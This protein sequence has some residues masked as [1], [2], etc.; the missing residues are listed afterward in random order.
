MAQLVHPDAV[1]APAVRLARTRAVVLRV[2]YALLTLWALAMTLPGPVLLL[3]GHLP[4]GGW[5]FVAAATVPWKLLSTG[6]AAVVCASAGRNVHAVRVLLL[7]QLCWFVAEL[8]S[9]DSGD[10]PATRVAQVVVGLAIWVGPWLLLAPRRSRLWRLSGSVRAVRA[11]VAVL[12][13]PLLIWWENSNSHLSIAA[14]SAQLPVRELRFD[15]VGLPMMLLVAAA[16]SAVDGRRWWAAAG[17]AAY[18][19]VGVFG[20]AL[21]HEW[22]SPGLIGGVLLV[23]AGALL[24]WDAS[25]ARPTPAG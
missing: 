15:M 10:G 19:Y 23:A 3:S 4:A 17:A 12:A 16:L 18:A 5:H 13:A 22:G 8:V 14:A 1:T 20:V 2:V 11:G 21:P 7:G 6:T 24:G 25:R 9:P